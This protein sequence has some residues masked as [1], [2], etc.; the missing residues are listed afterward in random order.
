MLARVQQQYD[1]IVVG[2]GPAGSTAANLG[3]RAGLRV[4]VLERDV[5]PRFHVGESLLPCD[6]A[7]FERLGLDCGAE[8]YLYKAGADFIDERLG[9][10][11][12]YLFEDALEGTPD[13]AYQV[14]R[15]KFDHW[16][17]ESAREAGAEVHTG[18]RALEVETT[19]EGVSVRTETETHR[20]RFLI[21]A[22]GQDSLIGRRAR[23]TEPIVE[24]G[25]A[26]TFA[27]FEGVDP[28]IDREMCETGRGNVKILFVEDGWCWAIP[29]GG[30]RI[31]A[32]MVTRRKGLK[33]EWHGEMIAAS[34]LLSRM[35]RGATQPR[36]PGVTASFSFYNKKQNG[37]RWACA[38][39]SACFLD[40]IFSSG[41]SLGMVGAADLIDVLAPALGQGREAAPD[42]M[43][44]H[45]T[46]LA[47]GYDVF[48]TLIN[49]WYHTNLL[50]GLFFSRD[51][52]PLLRKGLT[53]VLAGDVWRDDNP[54]QTMLMTS[55]RRRK[56]L[57]PELPCTSV[58]PR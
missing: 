8:G 39:D 51:Q 2:G 28:G 17:L 37:A 1:V 35:T 3:S 24:F 9:K 20:G 56:A 58:D 41:V 7:V 44:A 42:L 36:K 55:K 30:R 15:A 43:N 49:S 5:F 21:D 4:L 13:H 31:S 47:K 27:H 19:E 32:G 10:N 48:A 14:E 33:S 26:A 23:T 16:L 12:P 18:E 57:V 46:H 29:L 52:D 53:S 54:F 22:T 11:Q 40:P 25:L 45:V 34:P 50:H 38:G 6:L